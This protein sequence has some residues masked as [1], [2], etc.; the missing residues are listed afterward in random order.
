MAATQ[1]TLGRNPT[2]GN[3]THDGGHENRDDT[4]HG[5]ER[6]DVLAHAHVSQVNTHTGEVSS[7]DSKLKEVHHG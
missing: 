2:V 6:S 3:D 4:L 7:P 5:E 1:Q